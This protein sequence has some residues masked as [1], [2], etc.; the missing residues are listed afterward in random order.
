MSSKKEKINIFLT[1]LTSFFTD[2]SSELIYPILP[3]F[4]TKALGVTPAIVGII[5]G[6]SES[7]ASISKAYFGKLSDKLK[8]YKA[9]TIIGYLLSALSKILLFFANAWAFVLTARFIDR[10]GKGIRTAP[11]DAIISESVDKGERGKAFGIQRA[12]D[13]LGAF[14][15]GLFAFL[16]LKFLITDETEVLVF[17]KIFM[18]SVIPGL[19]GLIFLFFVIVPS[20]LKQLVKENNLTKKKLNKKLILFFIATA[21]FALGNSS[22]QFLLLKSKDVGFTMSSVALLYLIYNFSTSIFSPVFGKISD[23]IGKKNC[24]IL[25]YLL[26]TIVYAS[27]GFV[28]NKFILPV[29]WFLYAIYSA[30][31]EGVEKA[32][33]SD[34]SDKEE[35]GYALGLFSTIVGLGV[36]PASLIAG[37]LYSYVSSS[38]PFLLGSFLAFVATLIIMFI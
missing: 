31:T 19:I 2:I 36:L 14:I 20:S 38:S 7:T 16:F 10:I 32:Y 3:F 11:R 21:I 17:K 9:L 1:G 27:F 5:E 13:F 25:G 24:L 28:T 23:K 12:M 33:V 35:R 37:Y 18:I 8:T 4:L 26:Y 34:L 15:G 30:M 29:T 6:I 22:N